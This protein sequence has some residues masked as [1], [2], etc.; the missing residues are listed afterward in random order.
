MF[1]KKDHKKVHS[2]KQLFLLS[3]RMVLQNHVKQ[4]WKEA[5]KQKQVWR[6]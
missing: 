5:W 4:K 2:I 3:I 1:E 6:Y